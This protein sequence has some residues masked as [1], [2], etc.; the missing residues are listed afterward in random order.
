MKPRLRFVADSAVLLGTFIA[1]G[2]TLYLSAQRPGP[3][4]VIHPAGCHGCSA[5][6]PP[7]AIAARDA[8]LIAIRAIDPDRIE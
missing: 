3:A 8:Y 6:A 7:K 4:P 1:G 5:N 2:L